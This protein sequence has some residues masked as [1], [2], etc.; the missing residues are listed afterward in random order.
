MMSIVQGHYRH[1]L[2]PQVPSALPHHLYHETRLPHHTS[3]LRGI[4][5]QWDCITTPVAARARCCHDTRRK[6]LD[7]SMSI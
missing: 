5:A 7:P 2:N 1:Q 4:H 3:H 6:P